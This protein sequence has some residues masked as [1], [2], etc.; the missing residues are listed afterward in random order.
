MLGNKK[1]AVKIYYRGG[2]S[3]SI[4]D[5]KAKNNSDKAYMIKFNT[6]YCI[7]SY[8]GNRCWNEIENVFKGEK[9]NGYVKGIIKCSEDSITFV[10]ILP[11]IKS[12]MD[13]YISKHPQP[14]KEILQ[15]IS[16]EIMISQF[17]EKLIIL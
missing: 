1:D 17:L 11:F 14:E 16:R 4:T 3:Y 7:D 8:I 13:N 2:M 9:R 15:Y 10:N 12:A 5:L 6:E